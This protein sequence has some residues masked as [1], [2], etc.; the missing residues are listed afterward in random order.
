MCP[1][2]EKR[3]I[4]VRLH[5]TL[6]HLPM[7]HLG[8]EEVVRVLQRSNRL[9]H[10]VGKEVETHLVAG[11][12]PA[13]ALGGHKRKVQT[14]VAVLGGDFVAQ[15]D[16]VK[17]LRNHTVVVDER[18]GHHV[19]PAVR[20]TARIVQVAVPLEPD[21]CQDLVRWPGEWVVPLPVWPRQGDG[22]TRLFRAGHQAAGHLELV[23]RVAP[24]GSVTCSCPSRYI[25]HPLR[26]VRRGEPG[27]ERPVGRDTVVETLLV[28]HCIVVLEERFALVPAVK[29]HLLLPVLGPSEPL[30]AGLRL[31]PR[32]ARHVP[33]LLRAGRQRCRQRKVLLELQRVIKYLANRVG[34]IRLVLVKERVEV[35]RRN[36]GAAVLQAVGGI[37]PALPDGTVVHKVLVQLGLV[38]HALIVHARESAG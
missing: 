16:S 28:V 1:I 24:A 32:A 23:Q 10:V 11:V 3:A 7:V 8:T 14:L 17:L 12:H 6:W 18:L 26:L 33:V 21:P 19:Q 27:P 5:T 36:V 35:H 37:V 4:C 34:D 15:L 22:T 9:A 20:N 38:H 29:V 25:H 30:G 13:K 2:T 31:L